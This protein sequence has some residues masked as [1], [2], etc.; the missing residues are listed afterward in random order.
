MNIE[1]ATPEQIM[2]DLGYLSASICDAGLPRQSE[3]LTELAQRLAY[4]F[5]QQRQ[6][7]L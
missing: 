6:R 5:E 1:D 4:Y 3:A 2:H 7:D